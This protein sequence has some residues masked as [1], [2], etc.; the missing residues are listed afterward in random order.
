MDLATPSYPNPDDL[1]LEAVELTIDGQL[2]SIGRRALTLR[3]G[4]DKI[5]I[6]VPIEALKTDLT[7]A[8]EIDFRLDAA[9]VM[10]GFSEGRELSDIERQSLALAWR[11]CI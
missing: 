11:N 3:Y 1:P 10:G 7:R 8:L 4:D 6:T 5:F 2:H 9:R